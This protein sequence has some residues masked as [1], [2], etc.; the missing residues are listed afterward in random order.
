M[1]AVYLA[2][3]KSSRMGENKLLLPLNN[4]LLGSLALKTLMTSP[5]VEYVL[6]VVNKKDDLRWINDD[7]L[8]QLQ[9]GR[10]EIIRCSS[11]EKGMGYSLKCGINKAMELKADRAMICLADQPFISQ[12]MILALKRQDMSTGVDYIASSHNGC[13]IPPIIFGEKTFPKLRNITGDYGAKKLIDDGLLQG[14]Q[15]EFS[16][17][18]SFIDIDTKEVYQK[19]IQS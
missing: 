5:S 4:D 6:I 13:I 10:G 9:H 16:D 11:A 14:K 8:R 15:I 1:I 17:E 19:L 7:L 18:Y 3:G 2:A 12:E